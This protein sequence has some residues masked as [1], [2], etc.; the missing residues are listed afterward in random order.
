MASKTPE[1]L[2]IEELVKTKIPASPIYAFLLS[3]IS[4]I[5]ADKGR[6]VARLQL[7]DSHMN[8]SKSLHGA[9]S[10]AIVDWAGGM[11][12]STY[13]L[14]PSS[15]PSLDIHVTYQSGAKV[16]EEIEIEGIAE[17]VGGSIGFT[18]ITI[19][20]VENGARGTIVSAGTHTK[21]VKGSAP[22]KT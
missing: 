7:T 9:V 12:I 10:A 22:P 14:R 18:K 21:Y 5:A 13:D 6:V 4:I 15:G 20:K 3:D 16:G 17:R 11:A 19:Y 8:A 1:H 2:H